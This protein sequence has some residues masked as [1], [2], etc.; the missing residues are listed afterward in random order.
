MFACHNRWRQG[1][2]DFKGSP[3][4]TRLSQKQTKIK[5]NRVR[6]LRSG[7]CWWSRCKGPGVEAALPPQEDTSRSQEGTLEVALTG[8]RDR[9]SC[10]RSPAGQQPP[11][12]HPRA[13]CSGQNVPG[14]GWEMVRAAETVGR[15]LNSRPARPAANCLCLACLSPRA[16][17]QQGHRQG[18]ERQ[19][20]TWNL[21]PS[22]HW[23]D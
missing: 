3:H 17:R 15:F 11:P 10:N 16:Q 7:S 18:S 8:G 22:T 4:Y 5:T 20:G 19:R 14:S 23:S 21:T 6:R 13:P 12:R 2:V 1:H 9:V